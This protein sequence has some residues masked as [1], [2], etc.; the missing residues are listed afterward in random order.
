MIEVTHLVKDYGPLRAL[1]GVSFKVDTGEVVGFLGPNGAGKTTCMKI[2][3]GFIS[4]TSGTVTVDGLDSVDSGVQVRAKMG[5]LPENAPVYGEMTVRE[6]LKFIGRVRSIPE[7]SI[8]RRIQEIAVTTGLDQRM[9]QETG[10]L[11]R[12][13]R[14]RTGLAAALIHNPEI[15]ILDE[16]TTGLDP[17]QIVDIRNLIRELGRDRTVILSTHNM[18]EVTAVCNRILIVHQGRIVA[19]GTNSEIRAA[20]GGGDSCLVTIAAGPS[21]QNADAVRV[22]LEAVDGCSGVNQVESPEAGGISFRVTGGDGAQLRGRIFEL[23]VASNWKL[24]ELRSEQLDL[25]T[26]FHRLTR[27]AG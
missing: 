19:D 12:G 22:R 16:P 10:T 27:Q 18:S 17:N 9:D 4:A 8:G 7:K 26:I 20:H 3:T 6:Y 5:Y 23:A 15:L 13:F 11:S 24:V 25:E 14:Q 2:I 21:V 1:D